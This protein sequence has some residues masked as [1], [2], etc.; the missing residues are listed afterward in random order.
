MGNLDYR[1]HAQE[2]ERLAKIADDP[3]LKQELIE[4]ARAWLKLEVQNLEGMVTQIAN[5][6]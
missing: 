1:R 4:L 6:R 3:K 2:C 5:D